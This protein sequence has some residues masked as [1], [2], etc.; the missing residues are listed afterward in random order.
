M[1]DLDHEF[2]ARLARTWHRFEPQGQ[3]LDKLADMLRPMDEAGER[4]SARV[5]FDDEPSDYHLGMAQ[6]S[7]HR[8]EAPSGSCD[9]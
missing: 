9:E 6:M 5:D 1:P 7:A 4:L 2:V 8:R 3:D